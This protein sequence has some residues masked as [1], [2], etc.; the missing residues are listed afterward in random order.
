MHLRIFERGKAQVAA[1]VAT[2]NGEKRNFSVASGAAS[3]VIN[4]ANMNRNRI[5]CNARMA[6]AMHFKH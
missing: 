6:C 5:E 1:A 3:E 4:V 2:Q